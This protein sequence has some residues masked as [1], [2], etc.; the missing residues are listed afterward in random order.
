MTIRPRPLTV[1]DIRAART[2]HPDWCAQGH[3][4]GLGEHRARPIKLTVRG[5]ASTVLTRVQS[6]DGGEHAEIRIS[7]RLV[8]GGDEE[9]RAHLTRVLWE[10]DAYLRRVASPPTR[11]AA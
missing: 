5:R 11:R 6:A 3:A 8:P 4:C 10:L 7:V 2:G 9:V 1:K